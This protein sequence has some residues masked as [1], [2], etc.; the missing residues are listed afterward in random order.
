MLVGIFNSEYRFICPRTTDSFD[1]RRWR[2]QS[3]YLKNP[4]NDANGI[5]EALKES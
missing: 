4:A 1:N 2:I 3:S 5:A